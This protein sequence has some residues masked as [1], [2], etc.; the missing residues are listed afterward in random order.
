[1]ATNHHIILCTLYEQGNVMEYNILIYYSATSYEFTD[2][3][4]GCC[5][6]LGL[7]F[8]KSPKNITVMDGPPITLG[9]IT[10]MIY[11]S[12]MISNYQEISFLFVTK[13]FHHPILPRIP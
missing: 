13:L 2:K 8:L 10:H 4:C 5:Y 12:L 6:H 7:H 9:T 3:D 1:M 11:T